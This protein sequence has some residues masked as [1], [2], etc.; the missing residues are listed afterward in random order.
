[1][2]KEYFH[3]HGG[4][5]FD[6]DTPTLKDLSKEFQDENLMEE[7]RQISSEAAIISQSETTY[8]NQN[9]VKTVK[10]SS[11]NRWVRPL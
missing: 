9:P 1:M 7:I 5:Q 4:I 10:D 2:K 6:L 8:T 11:G 3:L